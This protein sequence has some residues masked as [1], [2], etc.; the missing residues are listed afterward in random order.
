M[1]RQI[2]SDLSAWK[3]SDDRKPLILLGARQV[4]KTWIMQH[5][6]KQ[7]YDNI[8]YINCDDEPRAKDMFLSDYDIYSFNYY[9]LYF[10]DLEALL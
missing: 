7:E 8:A 4:G 3:H 6:G 10:Q 5:F 1:N 9:V 2:Y